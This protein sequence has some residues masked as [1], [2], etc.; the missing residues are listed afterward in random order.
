MRPNTS[1][2]GSRDGVPRAGTYLTTLRLTGLFCLFFLIALGLGYPMLNRYDPRAMPGLSDVKSYA[3]LVAGAPNPGYDHLQFRVL[4]PWVA[5]LACRLSEGRLGS[6]D[7]VLFGLLAADS[8]FVAL[9]AV[10]IVVLGSRKL[11]SYPVSLVS[12]L[13]YL[14]NFSI[15]N[16]RLVGLVDAGEGFF[17]LAL[18]WTLSESAFWPIPIIALFGTITKESFIPFMIV[19]TAAW[20]IVERKKL[21]SP[22]TSGTWIVS[23]WLFS[24]LVMMALQWRIAGRLSDPISFAQS[25]HHNHEYLRHLE[26]SLWDKTFLYV[27]SWLVPIGIPRLGRLPKSWLIPTAVT[28][29][30]AFVLDDYYGAG[31]GTVVR[32]LFSIAGPVLALSAGLFLLGEYVDRFGSDRASSPE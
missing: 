13:L 7:P 3:A 18:L 4:V 5:R 28:S 27:F 9:T 21:K 10:L 31:T 22:V 2:L 16:L 19:F 25:L 26:S 14:V 32:A 23:A 30:L 20:W 15:P 11:G 17:L 29:L 8:L 1:E 12:A 24:L 6:W